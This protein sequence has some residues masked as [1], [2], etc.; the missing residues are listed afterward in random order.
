MVIALAGVLVLHVGRG[1]PARE[2]IA[3]GSRISVV[4]ADLEQVRLVRWAATRF[5]SAGLETP[6]TRSPST[7][8]LRDA[9]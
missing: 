8:T 5:A 6:R 4:E 7:R 1:A 9:A 3:V 2:A